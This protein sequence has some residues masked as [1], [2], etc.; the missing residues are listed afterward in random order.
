MSCRSAFADMAQYHHPYTLE[1]FL[2][3][4][5]VLFARLLVCITLPIRRCLSPKPKHANIKVDH[6][7]IPSREPGRSI[8]VIRY[9]P[10]TL[11]ANGPHKVH[12]NWHG[13]GFCVF[14]R[15]TV[16]DCSLATPRH[17]RDLLRR[18][19]S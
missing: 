18:S 6:F 4:L 12:L 2:L 5:Q 10:L 3:L 11:P 1:Y 9:T 15:T 13:S 14:R 17:G 19:R 8:R 16:A 7:K